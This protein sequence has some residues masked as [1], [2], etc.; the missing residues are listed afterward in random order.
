MGLLLLCVILFGFSIFSFYK[1]NSRVRCRRL[2]ASR[3]HHGR[4]RWLTYSY[5]RRRGGRTRAGAAAG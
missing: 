2:I 3:H 4:G 1:H 5:Y